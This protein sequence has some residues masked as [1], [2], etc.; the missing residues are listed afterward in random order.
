MKLFSHRKGLRPVRTTLQVDSMDEGLWNR[1]WNA[2]TLFYWR[3]VKGAWLS[4]NENVNALVQMLWHSYFKKPTDTIEDLWLKTHPVIRAWY[5]KFEW[6]EV[7][8]FLEF[9][10]KNYPDEGG[11]VNENFRQLCNGILEE[12]LSAY[13]F[14]GEE[15]AEITSEEE[16][17][18]IEEALGTGGRLQPVAE[19]L[20]Q[21]LS[22]L[23]DRKSPDYRNSIKESISAVEALCKL[24]T[25]KPKA[26]FADGLREIDKRVKL[27][28]ALK[29]SFNSMYGYTSDADGIRHAL[30]DE[31]SLNFEDAKLM[32]VSCSAFINYVKVKAS[33]TGL[34]L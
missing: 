32:L 18:E 34:K 16:I 33:R 27:H 11:S 7:Y 23:S 22:L 24:I 15:I 17:T 13:R 2:L 26:E 10:S 1:L 9:V 31:P 21:A 25:G 28:P 20:T 29:N 8:D 3:K 19:H 5:F 12:E 6:Y 30:L 4:E 14:V